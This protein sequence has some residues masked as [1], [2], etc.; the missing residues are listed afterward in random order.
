MVHVVSGT[1]AVEVDG[2]DYSVPAG[3]A[4]M[5]HAERPHGYHNRGDVD[6]SL[7]MVVLQPDDDLDEWSASAVSET[8][9]G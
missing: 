9:D 5:F 7:V 4:A 2:T 6:M 3:G 1:L 8:T